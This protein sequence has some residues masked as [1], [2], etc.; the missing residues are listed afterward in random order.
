M[1]LSETDL[2]AYHDGELPADHA[3]RASSHLEECPSCRAGLAELQSQANRVQAALDVLAPA[4]AQDARQTSERAWHAF[5]QKIQEKPAMTN[6]FLRFRAA[7]IGL[8]AVLIVALALSIPS[9]QAL[10][11]SFLSIFR[12]QQVAV[13]PLDMTNIKDTRYDPS[14]GQTLGQILSDQVKFSRK[15]GKTQDVADASAAAKIAGFTPRLS[16]DPNQTLSRIAVQPGM[17]FEGTFDQSLAMQVLASMNKGS[18][19]LPAGLDGAVIKVNVPD[20]IT[21]AYGRCRYSNDPE[22]V[23]A[24]GSPALAIGDKCL[25]LVQLPSPT[26]DTPPDLPVTQL[27]EIGLQVLGTAPDKAAQIAR[28][29]DWTTTLVIPIP[30]GEVDS[31]TV[32]VDGQQ[33]S[34]MIQKT[35]GSSLNP[36]YSLVWANNGIVYAIVGTGDPENGIALGNSLK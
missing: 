18:L 1:H 2:R 6:P 15:P 17:A 4:T 23:S 7:W 29:I 24:S 28:S 30:S 21:T 13:L 19:S 26:V 32:T 25:L 10:A 33:A 14:L 27:A 35:S 8:A 9:V 3:A 11:S 20:A 16:S 34:L 31:R 22:N 5:E 12:V 36:G